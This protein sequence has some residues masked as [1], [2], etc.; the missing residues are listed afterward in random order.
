MSAD[1]I[2]MLE[3]T[4][5]RLRQHITMHEVS[6]GKDYWIWQGDGE[7]HP[8][9]LTCPV[10]I[11]ADDLRSILADAKQAEVYEGYLCQIASIFGKDARHVEGDGEKTIATMEREQV[12]KLRASDIR[13]TMFAGMYRLALKSIANDDALECRC[14][15]DPYTDGEECPRCTAIAVLEVEHPETEIEKLQNIIDTHDLCHDKDQNVGP[16][17]YADGCSAQQR[18]LYGCAPDAD[19]VERLTRLLRQCAVYTFDSTGDEDRDAAA[20][21]SAMSMPLDRI[22]DLIN[23]QMADLECREAQAR[24]EVEA[25]RRRFPAAGFDGTD[26]V[27][28]G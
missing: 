1:H 25:W 20:L 18:K 23:D 24:V 17:E 7:D 11:Q 6:Q 22:P 27:M 9:S 12:D 15:N 8:E 3:D 4:I 13:R 19:E 14:G 16:R 10:L 21:T 28:S 26:I 5:T 2:K